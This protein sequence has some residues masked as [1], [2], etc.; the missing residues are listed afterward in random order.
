MGCKVTF[1]H[2]VIDGEHWIIFRDSFGIEVLKIHKTFYD[3]CLNK[4]FIL[5][6]YNEVRAFY[7]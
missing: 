7:G 1:E 4:N 3:G 2:S 6:I 5:S